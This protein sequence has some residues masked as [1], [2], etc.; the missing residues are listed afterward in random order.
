[1]KEDDIIYTQRENEKRG[2][3]TVVS[4][5]RSP[6]KLAVIFIQIYASPPPVRDL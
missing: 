2:G 4:F 3:L 6:V 1:M 5:D